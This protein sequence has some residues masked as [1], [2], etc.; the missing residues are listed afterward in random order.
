MRVATTAVLTITA[1]TTAT[2]PALATTEVS[3]AD[4]AAITKVINVAV[5]TTDP[6]KACTA[7]TPAFYRAMFATKKSCSAA[8][9]KNT[10]DA[11]ISIAVYSIKVSGKKA[12]AKITVQG[13]DN[14]TGTWELVR[15][16]KTWQVS[17]IRADYWRSAFGHAFGPK[18]KS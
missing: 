11:A 14:G 5:A 17:L 3:A 8:K 9:H 13:G 1:L 4:R 16:G 18:Y 15:S 12:T 7:Y 6:A 10:P 2:A